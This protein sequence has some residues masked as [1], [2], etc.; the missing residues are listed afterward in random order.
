[1]KAVSPVRP[2]HPDIPEVVV[3][4]GQSEY[5]PVPMIIGPE[6]HY[7]MTCRFRLS[8]WEGVRLLFGGSIWLSQLTFGRFHPV[9]IE[10][11]EP[12]VDCDYK[13]YLNRARETRNK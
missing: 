2:S 10:L 12:M 4:E 7:M 6:P 11:T 8:W 13:Y 3:G 1:M 5:L 9:K